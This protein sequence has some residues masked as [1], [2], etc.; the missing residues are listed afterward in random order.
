MHRVHNARPG[1]GRL[2]CHDPG[3]RGRPSYQSLK[4][5]TRKALAREYASLDDF[6]RRWSSTEKKQAIIEETQILTISPYTEFG[7]PLETIRAFGGLDQ[8]QKAVGELE[9]ALYSA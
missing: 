9:Q 1:E 5:Y 3:Q 8:H 7:T 6:L 2:V 4:D